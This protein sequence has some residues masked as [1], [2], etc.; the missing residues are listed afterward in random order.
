ME[1]DAIWYSENNVVLKEMIYENDQ[2]H[3][4]AKFYNL[5]GELVSEGQY[6]RD[7]KDGLLKY[8][9]ASELV[10]ETDFTYIKI[11]SLQLL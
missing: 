6:K 7:K 10:K 3:G 4:P 1:G 5:K 8:Y 9:E 11:Y 2:L